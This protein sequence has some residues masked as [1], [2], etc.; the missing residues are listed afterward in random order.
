MALCYPNMERAA[1]VH[2]SENT[3]KTHVQSIFGKL[4][5]H[6]RVVAAMLASR[7]TC[8]E[9]DHTGPPTIWRLIEGGCGG[10]IRTDDLRV[11][12]PTSCRCSTP[13]QQYTS[14]LPAARVSLSACGVR[15]TAK[16]P[17]TESARQSPG[18]DAH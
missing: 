16:V 2:L 1:E 8:F 13:R 17:A 18:K 5:A 9:R 6:N 15:A 3:V 11:M 14:G 12:S 4:G 7:K 10:R